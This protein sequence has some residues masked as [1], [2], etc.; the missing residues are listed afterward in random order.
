MIW[1]KRKLLVVWSAS[2]STP[3]PSLLFKL[4]VLSQRLDNDEPTPIME[5]QHC[6]LR[7]AQRI[8]DTLR[9]A[10]WNIVAVHVEFG[11]AIIMIQVANFLSIKL[12]CLCKFPNCT[13]HTV[14]S[15]GLPLHRLSI[16]HICASNVLHCCAHKASPKRSAGE[17]CR[18]TERRQS[19]L[20]TP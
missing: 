2:S 9:H 3:L 10:L 19:S 11:P 14:N 17:V 5:R 7:T 6:K 8:M 15:F 1:M 18:M 16:E 13:C 20:R 4:H 12:Q